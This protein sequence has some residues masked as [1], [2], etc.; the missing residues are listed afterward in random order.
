M[1]IFHIYEVVDLGI[2]KEK[3]RRDFYALAAKRF[4]EEQ[5]H[6]LFLRLRDWEETHVKKFTQIRDSLTEMETQETYPGELNAYMQ[7]LINEKL[8]G[9]VT[10]DEFAKNVKTLLDAIRYGIAFEKDAILL[11]NEVSPFATKAHKELIQLLINEE[12]QHIIY[13]TDLRKTLIE[14]AK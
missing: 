11:F 13:L 2:E 3:K 7:T 5:M 12:K 9:V 10:P 8:Y 14:G 1:N 4:T 6:S